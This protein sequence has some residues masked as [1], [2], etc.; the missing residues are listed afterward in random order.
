MR[1]RHVDAGR[2][3]RGNAGVMGS[4]GDRFGFCDLA[5]RR[6]FARRALLACVLLLAPGSTWG[7]DAPRLADPAGIQPPA[8]QTPVPGY[9]P[10]FFD[11]FGRWISETTGALGARFR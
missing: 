10:G 9:K 8:V 3:L 7:Q 4:M 11:A 5:W 2:A 1:Q 6:R